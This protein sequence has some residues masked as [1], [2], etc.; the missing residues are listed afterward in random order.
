ML[1]VIVVLNVVLGWA[2]GLIGYLIELLLVIVVCFYVIDLVGLICLLLFVCLFCVLLL[3]WFWIVFWSFV[4]L[5]CVRGWI[6]RLIYIL[7]V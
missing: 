7:L 4:C 6:V 3:F 2:V 5:T 1:F